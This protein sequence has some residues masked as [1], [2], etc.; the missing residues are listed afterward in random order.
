VTGAPLAGQTYTIRLLFTGDDEDMWD[1]A[2]WIDTAGATD[3][4]YFTN[5]VDAIVRWDGSST[6]AVYSA[7]TF[8]ARHL[9]IYSNMLVFGDLTQGGNSLPGDIINSDV[10]DPEDT[11]TGLASQFKVHGGVDPILSMRHLG[12]YL[13][14]YSGPI[15]GNVVLAQFVGD[16]LVF[17]FREVTSDTGPIAARVVADYGDYHEFLGIDRT[18]KFDGAAFIPSGEQVWSSFLGRRDHSR[19]HLAFHMLVQEFGETIWALPLP[20][21]DVEDPVAIPQTA[22]VTH[23]TEQKSQGQPEPHSRRDFPFLS[24]GFE[25]NVAAMTWDETPG[26]WDASI[27]AWNDTSLLGAFPK[28]MAGDH[29]GNTYYLYQS[30]TADG[31]ILESFVKFGRRVLNDGVER[32][33]VQRIYPFANVP[34]GPA[35][36]LDVVLHLSDSAHG[37]ATATGPF[38]FSLALDEGEFFVSPFRRGRFAEVEFQMNETGIWE[39]VGYDWKLGESGGIR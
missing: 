8:K 24:R 15:I 32:G 19:Q 26:T 18:Y 16:P 3:Y 13:V 29:L 11:T 30:H 21:D 34:A 7:A 39:L 28:P 35:T 27:A 31:E 14:I 4:L 12:D 2:L 25:A 9:A 20:E 6:A 36:N 23:Y 37:T 33:L 22:F 10:G 5:G 17:V 1:T 38:P